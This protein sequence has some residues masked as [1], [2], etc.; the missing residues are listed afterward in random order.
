MK[1]KMGSRLDIRQLEIGRKGN[2]DGIEI[3]MIFVKNTNM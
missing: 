2:F 1:L 3:E